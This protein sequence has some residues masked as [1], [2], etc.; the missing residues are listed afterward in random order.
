MTN[1]HTWGFKTN[2]KLFFHSSGG[3]E[4]EMKMW[5]ALVPSGVSEGEISPS[6][7]ACGHVTPSSVSL[8]PSVSP[9]SSKES[10]HWI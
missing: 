5:V 8:Y 9:R 3:S 1:Q 10:S 2:K 4:Y 7:R 6:F